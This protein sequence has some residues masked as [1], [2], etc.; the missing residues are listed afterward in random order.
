[1]ESLAEWLFCSLWHW[2]MTLCGI[3]LTPELLLKV[4][5]GFTYMA[6]ALPGMD[7]RL[8]WAFFYLHSLRASYYGLTNSV[9]HFLHCGSRAP[10]ASFSRDK[11]NHLK[12]WFPLDEVKTWGISPDQMTDVKQNGLRVLKSEN[13]NFYGI[14]KSDAICKL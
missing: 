5:D 3:Q 10:R 13:R 2:P 8:H 11:N 9:V 7:P 1:M 4:Q 12:K 6:N 14:E